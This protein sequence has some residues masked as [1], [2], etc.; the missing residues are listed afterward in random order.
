MLR[1]WQRA[2]LAIV[3]LAFLVPPAMPTAPA[4]GAQ[5]VTVIHT[6]TEMIGVPG[7]RG[8]GHIT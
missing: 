4:Q 1:R 2:V 5:G 6:D 8:G 3:L 7:L